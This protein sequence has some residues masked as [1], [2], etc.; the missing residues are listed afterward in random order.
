MRIKLDE[1][2]PLRLAPRLGALGHDVVTVRDEGLVGADDRRI[3]EAAQF[4]RRFLVT[5]DLGFSEI[6]NFA[7]SG[8][9]GVLL[10]RLQEPSRPDL[11]RRVEAVFR[12]ENVESWAGCIVAAT[13]RK[14]RVRRPKQ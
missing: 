4:E 11:L 1:N 12:Q 5:Q 10:V 8:H 6:A 3:W 13:E 2:L 9:A 14:V 7:P